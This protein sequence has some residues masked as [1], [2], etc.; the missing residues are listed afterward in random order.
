[1]SCRNF[2]N[3]EKLTLK[4]I[5]THIDL[6]TN[7]NY[8]SDLSFVD[9]TVNENHESLLSLDIDKLTNN[10]ENGFVII[11]QLNC[12]FETCLNTILNSCMGYND[13]TLLRCSIEEKMDI[14]FMYYRKN[15]SIIRGQ[16]PWCVHQNTSKVRNEMIHFKRSFISESV[17]ML[18]FKIGGQYVA[19]F[20]TANN[21]KKIKEEHIKLIK[22]ITNELGL[23]IYDTAPIFGCDSRDGLINY[24]YDAKIIN[25]DPSRFE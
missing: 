12:F 24:I 17:L 10:M 7:E 8:E 11:T 5:D 25:V 3:M 22:L 13:E 9:L 19:E 21:M 20:F 18:N 6:M 15:W 4:I 23:S 16:N 1:M 2:M 14:I